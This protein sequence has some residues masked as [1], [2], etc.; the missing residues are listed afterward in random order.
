MKTGSAT[1]QAQAVLE[2]L[3]EFTGVCHASYQLNPPH[4]SATTAPIIR[5]TYPPEWIA[6]YLLR[7]YLLIDPVVQLG[8]ASASPFFWHEMPVDA[9]QK[10]FMKDA[11]AHGVGTDGFVIPV[12]AEGRRGILSVTTNLGRADW[13]ASV[14]E[15][16]FPL[17]A[18]ANRIHQLLCRDHA[19]D[20][21]PR[22]L[23]KR[24]RECLAW[25]ANGLDAQAIAHQLALSSH[26]VRGYLRAAREKLGCKT[27]SQA[28]AR[29]IRMKQIDP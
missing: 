19:H 22:L 1:Q 14:A 29:A 2:E 6:R 13:V 7:D 17:R 18:A 20:A 8:F 27:L 10:N 21:S 12:F 9:E 11:A 28:V 4:I 25:V 3:K 16:Q 24:E 5:T 23:A 26:T 15:Q